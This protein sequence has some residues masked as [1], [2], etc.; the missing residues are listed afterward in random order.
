MVFY[1]KAL[2]K[3]ILLKWHNTLNLHNQNILCSF[4]NVAN[5]FNNNIRLLKTSTIITNKN[6][7][8]CIGEQIFN[9]WSIFLG[10]FPKHV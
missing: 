1:V 9:L 8:K 5:V 3:S 4:L 7:Q 2:E 10:S 6:T